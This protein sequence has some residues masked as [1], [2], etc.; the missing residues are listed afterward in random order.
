M[1]KS[2]KHCEQVMN[3]SRAHFEQVVNKSRSSYEKS[4]AQLIVFFIVFVGAHIP[5]SYKSLTGTS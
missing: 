3:K 1:D 2:Q 5:L 4:L